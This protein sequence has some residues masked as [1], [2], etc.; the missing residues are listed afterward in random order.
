[1]GFHFGLQSKWPPSKDCHQTSNVRLMK[2][3]SWSARMIE[4]RITMMWVT[5]ASR[6]NDLI[7][8]LISTPIPPT[9]TRPKT[10]DERMFA[11]KR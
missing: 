4:T 9:P 3:G 5:N 11:S 8:G 10:R 2:E 1:M 6:R 7:D